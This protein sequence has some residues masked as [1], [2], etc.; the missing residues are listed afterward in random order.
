MSGFF[1]VG[2]PGREAKL[3][4]T[5]KKDGSHPFKGLASGL[6]KSP[7]ASQSRFH[8]PEQA[9][10]GDRLIE[11]LHGQAMAGVTR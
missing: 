11:Q 6:V 4:V 1:R 3:L 10:T 9:N 8:A 5:T 2:V 7:G